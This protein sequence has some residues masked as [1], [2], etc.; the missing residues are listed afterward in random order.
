MEGVTESCYREI[1]LDRNPPDALGGVFTEFVAVTTHAL[2]GAVLRSR[3]GALRHGAPVGVQLMGSNPGLLAV[4]AENAAA[5]KI[6]VL[7]INFGC[8]TKGTLRTCAGSA[9]LRDPA[10]VERIVRACVSGAGAMPVTAKIRAGFDSDC[11]LHD[12]ARA[13]EAGG[14]SMLTVHC[15]TRLEGYQEQVD[16]RRIARAVAAVSIPVCGNGGIRTHADLAR[17]RRE[18]GCAFAMVGRAALGNPWIFSGHVAT[19]AEAATFLLDYAQRLEG[20][21]FPRRGA[22]AR[23]KQLIHFWTAGGLFGGSDAA[24]LRERDHELLFHWLGDA[25]DGVMNPVRA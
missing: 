22:A 1:V 13:V 20:R 8:P 12:L 2:R 4:T 23:I 25:R 24:W 6:P 14:A 9:L 10:A 7:D 5:A 16:W 18:T 19:R 21:G 3:A 17:M 15:R 11:L